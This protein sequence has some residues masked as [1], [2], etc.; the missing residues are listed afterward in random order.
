MINLSKRQMHLDAPMSLNTDF[1]ADLCWWATFTEVWNGVSIIS[2][3]CRQPVDAWLTSDASGS[4][5]C[6]AYF[7]RCWFNVSW[8]ACPL[9][10]DVPIAVKE[11]LP[12]V[13]SCAL[14]GQQM[15]SLYVFC[16][17]DNAA[18]VAMIKLAPSC[19]TFAE[20]LVL[21]LCK[22]CCQLDGRASARTPK[23]SC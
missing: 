6:G 4:W 2:A 14:W 23:Q 22:I 8:I 19:H 9:W 10:E 11:L 20:M 12:I 7:R 21:Y 17:C 3:L 5:G 16:R 15:R 1:R 13:I 18:V